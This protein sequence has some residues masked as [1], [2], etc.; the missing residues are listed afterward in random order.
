MGRLAR[1]VGEGI[2]EPTAGGAETGPKR[3]QADKHLLAQ[4]ERRIEGGDINGARE[5]LVAL[6][7]TA[8]GTA[9]FALAET[10]DPNM[11]LAW[12]M[13]GVVADV[14]KARA[15]YLKALDLGMSRAQLRLEQL[16]ESELKVPAPVPAQRVPPS[17]APSVPGILLK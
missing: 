7:G 8:P 10:Y 1:E 16:P 17:A 3:L 14:A 12:G 4:A 9:A 11:L 5:I 15:L 2:A 6:E 13:R